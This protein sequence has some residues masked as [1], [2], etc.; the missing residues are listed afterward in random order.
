ML[1]KEQAV[2]VLQKVE[3]FLNFSNL[4]LS[5]KK[6][7]EK[8]TKEKELQ[9]L[10][11]AFNEIFLFNNTKAEHSV[12]SLSL[13]KHLGMD[14]KDLLEFFKV[15][16]EFHAHFLRH[17][18]DANHY[19]IEDENNNDTMILLSTYQYLSK[20]IAELQSKSQINQQS[21]DSDSTRGTSGSNDRRLRSNSVDSM[22]S[23]ASSSPSFSGAAAAN[24]A[25][26]PEPAKYLTPSPKRLSDITKVSDLIAQSLIDDFNFCFQRGYITEEEYTQFKKGPTSAGTKALLEKIKGASIDQSLAPH[27]KHLAELATSATGTTP[28]I[29]TVES[30]KKERVYEAAAA[31]KV[32]S[33]E[34]SSFDAAAKKVQQRIVDAERT[35]IPTAFFS[36]L[37]K[38]ESQQAEILR[39]EEERAAKL[40]AERTA[41]RVALKKQFYKPLNQFIDKIER[42]YSEQVIDFSNIKKYQ[43]ELAGFQKDLSADDV[44]EALYLLELFLQVRSPS[45][46]NNRSSKFQQIKGLMHSIS[47]FIAPRLG[48]PQGLVLKT[49]PA[50]SHCFYHAMSLGF[51]D[52]NFQT[53]RNAV[54]DHLNR[55]WKKFREH[56]ILE[57][58]YNTK[59]KYIDGIRSLKKFA[60]HIEIKV[61]T[62]VLK[63][64]IVILDEEGEIRNVEDVR[65]ARAKFPQGK[66]IFALYRGIQA[67]HYDGIVVDTNSNALE[68]LDN[69]LVAQAPAAADVIVRPKSLFSIIVKACWEG[70]K[71][72]AQSLWQG[73]IG[74]GTLTN[75]PIAAAMLVDGGMSSEQISNLLSTKREEGTSVAVAQSASSAQEPT[76]TIFN[77]DAAKIADNFEA[78]ADALAKKPVAFKCSSALFSLTSASDKETSAEILVER[79]LLRH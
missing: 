23:G 62:E 77:I 61:L 42:T 56:I 68:I 41:R 67:D 65:H 15:I 33:S 53:R 45:S 7:F 2:G 3:D 44:Q 5:E 6:P 19:F 48:L 29:P 8:D 37:S 18:K 76:V 49:V 34:Q 51:T 74:V 27:K 13:Q 40:I 9:A 47:D 32:S 22:I 35:V 21:L 78:L 1:T 69:L 43:A 31:A 66:P 60:D 10:G 57:G 4:Y 63:C 55:N 14:I 16:D 30:R 38:V 17:V 28:A 58:I 12:L 26:S 36:C 59:D 72:L 39:C 73:L 25:E 24:S 52:M 54:A 79:A 64:P 11:E 71:S 46:S 70:L 50:D 20:Q 75:N